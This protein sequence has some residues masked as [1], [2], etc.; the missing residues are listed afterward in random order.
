MGK[1]LPRSTKDIR[2]AIGLNDADNIA[3]SIPAAAGP[4]VTV[5]ERGDDAIRRSRFTFTN[6]PIS[7]AAAGAAAG[8]GGTKFYDM[9]EGWIH[10]STCVGS[11]TLTVETEADF[12]DGTPEG[13]IG[14]G[15]AAPANAD[16]LGTD[17][18]DDEALQ[19]ADFT[20][21]AYVA[22]VNAPFT[23]G[24]NLN[25]TATAVDLFFNIL[26]DAADIDNDATT[27][28]FV[29]GTLDLVWTLVGDY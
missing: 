17:S 23:G 10:F 2:D 3:G 5:E 12:T 14:V 20:M 24:A 4:Y 15:S 6:L 13:Q 9:P 16:A 28:V 11:F 29:S 22:N 21:A 26:V 8:V 7:V 25:G 27:N 1:G 18:T 19:A